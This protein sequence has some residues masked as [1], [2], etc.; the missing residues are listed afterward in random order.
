MPVA[1]GSN[2]Q[3]TTVMAR[4]AGSPRMRLGWELALLLVVAAPALAGCL[5]SDGGGET[6]SPYPDARP[7]E[8]PWPCGDGSEWPLD[9]VEP[10]VAPPALPDGFAIE[11]ADLVSRA[12][13][14]ATFAWRVPTTTATDVPG[15]SVG[16]SEFRE[17]EV[18]VPAGIPLR[19]SL[20][21][22]L[23][24]DV[25]GRSYD[26]TLFDDAGATLCFTDHDLEVQGVREPGGDANVG[27]VSEVVDALDAPAR[28]VVEL[29][30]E[31]DRAGDEL[32]VLVTV[33][34]VEPVFGFER[35]PVEP[36]RVPM[37]DGVELDGAL[38]RPVLP[39]GVRAP[40]VLFTT[41]YAGSCSFQSELQNCAPDV[42]SASYLAGYGLAD[43]LREGYAVAVISVRGTGASG[44][45]YDAWG[46]REQADHVELVEWLGAQAW[47]NGRVGMTGLSYAGA[48]PWEAAIHGAPA[49]KAIVVGGIISDPYVAGFTP[50]G[51]ATDGALYFHGATAFANSLNPPRD[52]DTRDRYAPHAGERICEETERE[53][54]VH[55]EGVGTD[56]RDAEWFSERRLLDGFPDVTAAALV[57]HGVEDDNFHRYQED[58]IWEFLPRAPKAMVLG[59]WDHTNDLEPQLANHDGPRSWGAMAKTWFDYWLK[60]LGAPPSMLGKVAYQDTELAWREDT[61][62]P[63][64]AL[65]EEVLYLAG[66]ALDVEPGA[67]AAFRAVRSPIF[68]SPAGREGNPNL[69]SEGTTAAFAE[70]RWIVYETEPLSESLLL[71]GNPYALLELTSDAPGGLVA[72]DLYALD[73]D[74]GCTDIASEGAADLRFHEG[75]MAGRDFPVGVRTSV[76]VDLH[77]TATVVPAGHRLAVVLSGGGADYKQGQAQYEPTLEVAGTS[78]LVLPVVEGTLGGDPPALAYPPRPFV[79]DAR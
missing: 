41:P 43:L 58:V 22:E 70:G 14:N 38:W 56:A 48:T 23:P 15:V 55:P 49:L 21:L 7:C 8:H 39:E 10:E 79:P 66:G 27:C 3:T 57:L 74:R 16:L 78:H 26:L 65:H 31:Q 72:V 4:G 73:P 32:V 30:H 6:R 47:S 2:G 71:A 50:Q 68:L 5:V 69:C 1:P 53:L 75:N 18:A 29:E 36:V 44:G 34:A 24:A 33:E 12:P 59:Q 67:G 76:R 63:P 11:G 60:G 20:D 51:A 17:L 28:Y 64:A 40:I 19:W 77:S 25:D 45:C 62:W 42:S 46:A 37:S 9:L 54:L 13:T 52:G 61:A 35:S